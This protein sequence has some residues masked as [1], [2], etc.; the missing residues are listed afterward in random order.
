MQGKWD[1]T[2]LMGTPQT[3]LATF[4]IT[5]NEQDIVWLGKYTPSLTPQTRKRSTVTI[6]Y[7]MKNVPT[8]VIRNSYGYFYH[9]QTKSDLRLPS[10][11]AS[12][13]QTNP[14]NSE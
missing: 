6:P 3:D 10:S 5:R 13:E 4:A 9:H 2:H 12:Y 14:E 1:S 7:N 11:Y 8:F